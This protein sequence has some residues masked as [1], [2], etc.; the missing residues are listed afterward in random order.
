M[1]TRASNQKSFPSRVAPSLWLA[2]GLA[3]GCGVPTQ[4]TLD[5]VAVANT[6]PAGSPTAGD[7]HPCS[8]LPPPRGNLLVEDLAE[9]RQRVWVIGDTERVLWCED[10]PLNVSG[11]VSSAPPRGSSRR[12]GASRAIRCPP[13]GTQTA[14]QCLRTITPRPLRR[15]P[16]PRSVRSGAIWRPARLGTRTEPGRR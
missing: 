10:L 7:V 4:S 13:K 16:A 15:R 14:I 11:S 5:T 8:D 6:Q 12:S 9:G 3:G 2:L 1:T